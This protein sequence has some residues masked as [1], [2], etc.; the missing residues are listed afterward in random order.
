MHSLFLQP[1]YLTF[2]EG[3]R[4]LLTK[5]FPVMLPLG[6]ARRGHVRDDHT[7]G[8]QDKPGDTEQDF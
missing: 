8:Q 1:C 6:D 7:G 4:V 5:A 3:A 2:G